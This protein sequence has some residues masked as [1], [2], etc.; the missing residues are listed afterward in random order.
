MLSIIESMADVG[1][2]VQ[3]TPEL[4]ESLY[5]K[6]SEAWATS[7]KVSSNIMH[8]FYSKESSEHPDKFPKP[9]QVQAQ[10]RRVVEH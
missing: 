10:G 1:C 4:Y 2:S 9:G 5:K 8:F 3:L 6:G 7:F